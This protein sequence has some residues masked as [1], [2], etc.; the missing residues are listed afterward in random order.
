MKDDIL[1]ENLQSMIEEL[2]LTN[3]QVDKQYILMRYPELL[4]LLKLVYDPRY[5][6]NITSNS[7]ILGDYNGDYNLPKDIYDL[8]EKLYSRTWT[9]NIAISACCFYISMYNEYSET[10]LNCINKD[11]RCGINTK[12]INKAYPGSIKEFNVPLAK[13]FEHKYFDLTYPW[14][15]SRKMDGIRC[16]VFI[17]EDS[18]DC[19]SREGIRFNTLVNLEYEL[20]LKWQGH[21]DIILD[22]ELCKI[23]DGEEDFQSL[24]TEARRKDHTM[25]HPTLF[26]F[27]MYSINSFENYKDIQGSYELRYTV[28]NSCIFDMDFIKVL[29]QRKVETLTDLMEI[30]ATRPTHWEGLILKH[31]Y[32]TNF[33]RS[34]C[35]L[36]VKDFKDAEYRVDGIIPGVKK[37][38]GKDMQ[39]ISSLIISHKGHG[40]MVGSGLSDEQRLLWYDNPGL[41]VGKTITVKYFSETLDQN[42]KPS[43]RFPIF[44]GIRDYE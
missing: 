34:N 32:R 19:Y 42:G 39:C 44:K 21:K 16:L 20:K 9:G 4:P 6:L 33:K 38:S 25:L 10:I 24:T 5:I 7:I 36:K 2:Q 22:G 17:R 27:D 14:Y 30:M 41:I 29:P 15:V 35:L 13:G 12:A 31:G 8:F 26:V 3:S 23:V 37:I 43:L 11:L 18:I 28:L 40:V 1:W